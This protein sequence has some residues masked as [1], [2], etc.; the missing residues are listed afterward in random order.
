[1]IEYLVLISCI[2]FILFL[3]PTR[4]R[5]YA[6]I[7][8][9]AGVVLYLFAE[10]PSYFA[11]N[12]FLYPILAVLSV[13]FLVVTARF[14]LAGE[15]RAMQ[16]TTAAAVAFLIYAPFAF[17]QPLG[18]WL[19]SVV[20]GQIQWVLTALHY[21]TALVAWDMLQ[22]NGFRIEII[23]ACTGIQAMA[24]MLGV[25]GAVPSTTRQKVLSFLLVVPTIYVLNIIRNVAV[26]IANTD[27]WFPYF[28]SNAGK[29]EYGYESFFWAHNVAAEGLALV[30]LIGIAYGLFKINPGLADFARDLF[31]NYYREFRNLIG[32]K[33][34][35]PGT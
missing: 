21:Q 35:K 4:F 24:I 19:I 3:I 33:K 10:I 14:L 23:L 13:P 12:N 5:N 7:V 15:N 6:G 27:P 16:L 28:P 26:I 22:R 17:I 8:G 25:A 9:W 30:L 34:E 1:M 31:D 2:F 32:G 18:D 11:E 29:G 20:V